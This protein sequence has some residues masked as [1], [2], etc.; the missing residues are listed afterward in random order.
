MR[1][2][3]NPPPPYTAASNHRFAVALWVLGTLLMYAA[4]VRADQDPLVQLRRGGRLILALPQ[5][6]LAPFVIDTPGAAPTGLD[7]ALGGILAR[8]LGVEL[9]ILPVPGGQTGVLDAVASGRAHLGMG[10]VSARPDLA[11]R[12][13]LSR[14]YTAPRQALLFNR[15]L[16]ARQRT[17]PAELLK[18]SGTHVAVV[19][20]EGATDLL[21]LVHP[22][23]ILEPFGDLDAAAR[24]V[25]AG[26]I[27][28][29]LN[30][31]PQLR[32]WLWRHAP[33]GLALG[34][35]PLPRSLDSLVIAVSWENQRL[36]GWLDGTLDILD[37][38]G[39]L[40]GL[41]QRYL[42]IPEGQDR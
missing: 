33:E 24:R 3:I 39:T 21:P 41:R 40:E 11:L 7:P 23:L 37:A 19:A 1:H 18:R 12:I 35:H 27:A 42:R 16:I 4:T 26:D 17:G 20:G 5:E 14:P 2:F 28:L 22:E 9:E 10:R 29:L 15:L 13:A 34:V 32:Y 31:E 36:L 8:C 38:D 6:G 30:D 25:A